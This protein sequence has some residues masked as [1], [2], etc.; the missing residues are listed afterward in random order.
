MKTGYEKFV[1]TMCEYMW[2]SFV[3]PDSVRFMRLY[4]QA[5]PWAEMLGTSEPE[6]FISKTGLMSFENH[7]SRS[8]EY[9]RAFDVGLPPRFGNRFFD[10]DPVRDRNMEVIPPWASVVGPDTAAALKSHGYEIEDI[11]L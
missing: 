5:G 1:E 7:Y 8:A 2:K 11:N 6:I 9:L 10:I 4:E 3:V